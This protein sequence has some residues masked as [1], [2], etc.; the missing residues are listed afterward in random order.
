[1][2]WVTEALIFGVLAGA[3]LAIMLAYR[4]IDLSA[5]PSIPA[6]QLELVKQQ[7]AAYWSAS[8]Y[9]ASLG[10]IERI[11]AI[12]PH[13][14]LSVMVLYALAGKKPIWFW[15]ALLWD[16]LIDTTAVYV[17]KNIGILQSEGIVAV[18][19]VVSLWIVFAMRPMFTNIMVQK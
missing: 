10:F 19:A 11:F 1:L 5:V 9:M 17:G 15:L 16:A 6:D 14:S 3:G 4:S 13:V 2:V 7:V 18:F 12:C 8:A